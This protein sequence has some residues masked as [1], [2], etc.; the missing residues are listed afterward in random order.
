MVRPNTPEGLCLRCKGSRNLCGKNPCPILAKH[1]VLRSVSFTT[2]LLERRGGCLEIASAS[3]PSFFVGHSGYPRVSIGPMLPHS[4]DS[5][6]EVHDMDAPEQWLVPG[7]PA[8]THK[9]LMEVVQFR[10]SL[11]RTTHPAYVKEKGA[12]DRILGL[13]Q[14]IAMA[15]KPVATEIAVEKLHVNVQVDDHA[16]PNGPSGS[17]QRLA[18][19][20]NP[21]VHRKVDYAVSD[22]DL[23]ASEAI[24]KYL[25]ADGHLPV[26]DIYRILSAGLLGIEENRKLVPT[27]WA[28]TATD[29]TVSKSL[30][31]R[32]KSFPE[33]GE[34][35]LHESSYLGN[36]FHIIFVPRPWVYEMMECWSP[37]SIWRLFDRDKS[38]VI[39]QDHELSDGRTT[40]ASNITGAYYSA[41]LGVAE[42]LTSI[43]RQA[44]VIVIREV[45]EQYLMP[46]GV[47]VI[48]QAVRDALAR[49]PR[50]FSSLKEVL[51]AIA[52]GLQ[53]PLRYWLAKSQ[54][55]PY[56][57]S[58]RTL[59]SFL[60]RAA[61]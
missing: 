30:I 43:K 36:S 5:P 56:I 28:I 31:E 57:R 21:R 44:A 25:Y 39:V 29:D 13:S 42:Y 32:V 16:A 1:A 48:R 17:L 9:Q 45:N 40:Y 33:L 54:L 18:I 22:T 60:P 6:L 59:E 35:L 49:P 46:L 38:Y 4:L 41:R 53:V 15:E 7:S 55:L 34:H 10:S 47:W 19:T 8:S 37:H 58:Q 3:P 23:K 2:D 12:S 27:R 50:K 51:A 52:P 14:Q 61:P 11:I 26:S 24:S 20:E